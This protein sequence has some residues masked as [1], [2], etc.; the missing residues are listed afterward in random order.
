M[1]ALHKRMQ[2]KRHAQRMSLLQQ[3]RSTDA[4]AVADT[5]LLADL[6]AAGIDLA[7]LGAIKTDLLTQQAQAQASLV[8]GV[9]VITPPQSYKGHKR[10][11]TRPRG[12]SGTTVGTYCTVGLDGSF[13][14]VLTAQG[15]STVKVTRSTPTG[16]SISQVIPAAVYRKRKAHKAQAHTGTQAQRK[17]VSDAALA[18]AADLGIDLDAAQAVTAQDA[19]SRAAIADGTA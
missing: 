4:A 3:A 19:A 5:Q 8:R 6:A 15:K 12:W 13:I 1:S 16:Y 2:A 14:P 11:N 9:G 17:P 10:A 18:L 7:S